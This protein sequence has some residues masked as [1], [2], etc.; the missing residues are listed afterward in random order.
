MQKNLAEIVKDPM[1]WKDVLNQMTDPEYAAKIKSVLEEAIRSKGNSFDGLFAL[2]Q[3]QLQQNDLEG[4]KK[5]LWT[6]VT[7]PLPAPTAPTP[8]PAPTTTKAARNSVIFGSFNQSPLAQRASQSYQAI[9]EAQQLLSASSGNQGR[10]GGMRYIN[11]NMNVSTTLTPAAIKDRALVYLSLIAVQQKEAEAFLKDLKAKVDSEHWPLSEQLVAY[12]MI[13]ASDPLLEVIEAEAKSGNPDHDADELAYAWC[14]RF[15]ME[16]IPDD[17]KKRAEAARTII[18]D[19][20]SQDP[21]FK[22]QLV[23]MKFYRELNSNDQSPEGLKKRQAAVTEFIKGLDHKD[24]QVLLQS[25]NMA[26]GVGLWDQA[27]SLIADLLA[28]DRTTWSVTVNQQISYLPVGLLQATAQIKEVM[29]KETIP[30]L[31]QLMRLSCPAV[32]PKAS[33]PATGGMNMGGVY[34]SRS[35]YPQDSFPPSNRYFPPDRISTLEPMFGQLKARDMVPAMYAALDQEIKDQSDW[36]KVYP[37][38]LSICFH[39]WDGKHDEA[40]AATRKLLEEDPSDDFRLLLASMLV[41]EKKYADAIPVLES[42]TAR[43]GPDYIRTQKQLL[44]AARLAKNQDVGQ[45]AGMRLLGL[46]L[47]QQEMMQILEDLREVGLKEKV[48]EFT[49]KQNG[50]RSGNSRTALYQANNQLQQT[51]RE[52]LEKKNEKLSVDLSRQVLN[53]DPLAPQGMGNEN[54]LRSQALESLK[55]FG[56]LEAYVNDVDRQIQNTPDSIRLNW[57]AGEAYQVMEGTVQKTIG[58][59]PLP[60]WLKLQRT[61]NQLTASYSLDGKTWKPSGSTTMALPPKVVIGLWVTTEQLGLPVTAT[62]NQLAWTGKVSPAPAVATPPPDKEKPKAADGSPTPPAAKDDATE[63][64]PVVASTPDPL[65]QPWQQADFGGASPA[66]S[67]SVDPKGGLLVT[68][69][70][71]SAPGQGRGAHFVYQTLEGDGSLIAQVTDFAPPADTY[72][73]ARQT[74]RRSVLAGL[75]IRESTDAASPGVAVAV[76]PTDGITWLTHTKETDPEAEKAAISNRIRELGPTP[77]V[78]QPFPQYPPPAW[79]KLVRKGDYF[80]GSYSVDGKSWSDIFSWRVNLPTDLITGLMVL[81]N[82]KQAEQVAWSGIEVKEITAPTTPAPEVKGQT[83]EGLPTPWQF[84]SVGNN[85]ASASAKWIDGILHMESPMMPANATRSYGYVYRP[86]HGDGEIVAHLDTPASDQDG[87][88]AGLSF[89]AGIEGDS[90]EFFVDAMGRIGYY[91]KTDPA[92]QSMAYYKRVAQ[93]SP[94]NVAALTSIA[95][96]LVQARKP[97]AAADVYVTVLKTDFAGS[98]NRYYNIVQTFEQA[99]RLPEFVQIV[100]DW[101]P[102]PANPFGGG[103][104]MY[105]VLVQMGNQLQQNNHLPEAEKIY[106]KALTLDSYS[107][108]QE[109]V[110]ALAQVLITQNRR[111]EAAS[112]IENFVLNND[113][114]SSAATPPPVLGFNYQMRMQSS[115]NWYNSIGWSSNGMVVGPIVRFLEMADDLGLSDK[116]R[117]ELKARPPK[118]TAN[119]MIIDPDRITAILLAII[120]HDPAYRADLDKLLKDTP[121]NTLANMGGN[122]NALLII[123]RELQK[124]PEERAASV[125]LVKQVYDRSGTA[126]GPYYQNLIAMELLNAALSSGDHK[127]AQETLRKMAESMRSQRAINQNQVQFDQMLSVIKWMMQEGMLKEASDFLAEAKADT[128]LTAGNNYYT[129]KFEQVQNELAFANGEKSPL[130]L[131]YGLTKGKGDGVLFSWQI[132]AGEKQQNNNAYFSNTSWMN[133]VPVRPTTN[134]IEISVGP[135]RQHLTVLTTL[136]KVATSGSTPIKI[137]SG[138]RVLQASLLLGAKS[139]A[140]PVKP[141]PDAVPATAAPLAVG[142]LML[143]PSMENL[144]QNP[145]FKVTK[146]ASG[147]AQIVG[148]RGLT[149]AGVSQEKGGPVPVLGYQSLDGGNNNYGNT[150]EITSDRIPLAPE[151]SYVFGGWMRFAGSIKFRFYDAE[152]KSLNPNEVNYGTWDHFQWRSWLFSPRGNSSSRRTELGDSNS[153]PAKAVAMEIVLKPNQESDVADL[154]LRVLGEAVAP[155]PA[156]PPVKK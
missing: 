24:P 61:G 66:G 20:L 86:L 26:A 97:E 70:L 135:D 46:R 139:P 126:Q 132:N 35:Y 49:A 59:A 51:L 21:Q 150:A 136:D 14:E 33:L 72:V 55:L 74:D 40:I 93:L 60:Q 105:S 3:F 45:K 109:G 30:V 11:R 41:Q 80:T 56:Y 62:F 125:K 128:R 91:I 141:A 82:P 130:A 1:A 47:Q 120:Q 83:S 122:A 88:S 68:G 58:L 111:D 137:P 148:W 85:V 52:A 81:P 27:K 106:R 112:V 140:P 145:D 54:Y 28:T 50:T 142:H 34:Y 65:I 118:K 124:W 101:K 39:W 76:C 89:R 152:G 73:T 43:Y 123:A 7:E 6:I 98:M 115:Q 78:I 38:F 53:R 9:N 18:A 87:R 102:Q 143:V 48:D 113:S 13:Q 119:A 156:A 63:A 103:M 79:L 15:T 90:V 108:R 131:T 37:L 23:L 12:A 69:S 44:H 138:T 153:I 95:E 96:Q 104:D 57:L 147:K 107:G 42:V 92:M 154:S 134:K 5:T 36:K 133:G 19:R 129:D 32:Q 99:K 16:G 8:A 94:K 151:T 4:A 121:P 29:P 31:L 146:D 127:I 10:F 25:I 67:L 116:I 149:T 77:W 84:A 100:E 114:A 64:P 22:N 2:V 71:D 110:A 117:K 144:L 17:T 155:A 75:M